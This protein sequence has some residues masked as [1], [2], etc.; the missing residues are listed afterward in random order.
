MN[1]KL[2]KILSWVFPPPKTRRGW[3]I[4]GNEVR[5]VLAS[6][7]APED[8]QCNPLPEDGP[9]WYCRELSC[10]VKE[11]A[12]IGVHYAEIFDRKSDAIKVLIENVHDTISEIERGIQDDYHYLNCLKKHLEYCVEHK[13]DDDDKDLLIVNDELPLSAFE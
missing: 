10:V 1:D 2:F 8:R 9:F 7:R 6:K 11:K 5:N 12:A 13:D 4:I 3:V